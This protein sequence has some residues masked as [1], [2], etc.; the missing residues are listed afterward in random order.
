MTNFE[1]M[2]NAYKLF[3]NFCYKLG[4]EPYD[5]IGLGFSE[6]K[7]WGRAYWRKGGDAEQNFVDLNLQ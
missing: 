7:V 2:A 5:Q 4:L 3:E 6:N 1:L